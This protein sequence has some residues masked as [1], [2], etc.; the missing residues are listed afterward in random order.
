MNSKMASEARD[1]LADY[2]DAEADDWEGYEAWYYELADH[3]RR[4]P[5]EHSLCLRLAVCLGPFLIDDDRVECLMYPVGEAVTFTE[6]QTPT[7]GF[8]PYLESLT[9]AIEADHTRWLAHLET[10]GTAASWTLE[11]GPPAA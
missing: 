3:L 9:A 11:S 2:L 8:E 4:Q 6:N 5:P 1:Y 10:A 7:I